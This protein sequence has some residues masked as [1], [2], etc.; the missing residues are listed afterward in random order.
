MEARTFLIQLVLIL[1]SA[2]VVGKI[3]AYFKALSV[4]G[5]LVAI[6]CLILKGTQ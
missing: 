3:A 2:R 5:E 1:F 4:I 6:I